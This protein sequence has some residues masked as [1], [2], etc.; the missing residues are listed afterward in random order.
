MLLE[1]TIPCDVP[2]NGYLRFMLD[3]EENPLMPLRFDLDLS[4]GLLQ[5]KYLF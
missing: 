3:F 5:V 1:K 4:L 2:T